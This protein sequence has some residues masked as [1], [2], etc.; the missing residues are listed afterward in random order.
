M[1]P[2]RL[3]SLEQAAATRLRSGREVGHLD[4]HCAWQAV[5]ESKWLSGTPGGR[6]RW[7]KLRNVVL[8]AAQF[9]QPLRERRRR[10]QQQ[11]QEQEAAAQEAG[12]GQT[13]GYGSG[14]GAEQ[15]GSGSERCREPGLTLWLASGVLGTGTLQLAGNEGEAVLPGAGGAL[16]PQ[17]HARSPVLG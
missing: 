14:L 4:G 6:L 12:S 3:A 11:Q 1:A 7:A 10:R 13:G 2:G 5:L 9:R 16:Q 8:G 17:T 15:P